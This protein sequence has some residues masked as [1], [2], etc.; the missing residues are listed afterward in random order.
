MECSAEKAKIT[1]TSGL[2]RNA[3][4]KEKEGLTMQQ[5]IDQLLDS[6][7]DLKKAL[8]QKIE[9]IE[10]FIVSLQEMTWFEA[11]IYDEDTRRTVNDLISSSRDWSETLKKRHAICMNKLKDTVLPTIEELDE[12][13]SAIE[14]LEEA[15]NDLE[16]IVF[17]HSNDDEFG[18]ITSALLHI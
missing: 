4:F 17:F 11:S 9:E 18:E 5:K 3:S 13:K 8:S 10:E 2:V 15:T 7:L 16:S 14:D 6:I 1:E 12:F